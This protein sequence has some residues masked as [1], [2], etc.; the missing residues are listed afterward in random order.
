M[1]KE[2]GVYMFVWRD[3]ERKRRRGK[4]IAR[5]DRREERGRKE[6]GVYMSVW[7]DSETKRRRGK[8]IAREDRRD[9]RDGEVESCRIFDSNLQQMSHAEL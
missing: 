3:S 2:E 9:E 6:E 7:R 5:E 1:S 8:I 4:T